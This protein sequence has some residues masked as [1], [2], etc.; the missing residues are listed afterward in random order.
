MWEF[1]IYYLA[2]IKNVTYHQV[3]VKD[4]WKEK[5]RVVIDLHSSQ[6]Y[7]MKEGRH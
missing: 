6:P 2:S 7:W 4:K 1:G 5:I 3:S